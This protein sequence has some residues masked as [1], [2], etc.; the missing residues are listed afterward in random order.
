MLEH[1]QYIWENFVRKCG[2]QRICIAAHS[3]GG[4]CALHIVK[5]Y[6][7]EVAAKVK[8]IAL[9]DSVHK[10][11]KEL[12]NEQK[13]YLEKVGQ[14][15]KKSS[16]PLGVKVA[17]DRVEGC[18]CVSAGDPRHEYTSGSAISEVFPFLEGKIHGRK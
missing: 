12:N 15:W 13:K 9:L 1:T 16:K 7:R 5:T 14:N 6:F 11:V 2:A 8:G 17:G 10:N 4:V 18:S 3:C